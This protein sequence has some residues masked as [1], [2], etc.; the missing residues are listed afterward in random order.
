MAGVEIKGV[1]VC[2][3]NGLT[4]TSKG[5]LLFCFTNLL[6]CKC[7]TG[8]NV[9]NPPGPVARL[10]ELAGILSGRKTTVCLEDNEK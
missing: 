6:S 7:Q 2:D 4:L 1:I 9:S 3:S 8:R 5:I 10:T